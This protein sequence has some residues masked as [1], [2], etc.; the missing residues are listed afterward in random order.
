M[1]FIKRKQQ[2]ILA[3]IDSPINI[4]ITLVILFSII[5]LIKLILDPFNLFVNI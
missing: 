5:K 1:N 2:F 4:N 3:I